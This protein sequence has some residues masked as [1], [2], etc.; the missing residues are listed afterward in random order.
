MPGSRSK[1]WA[2]SLSPL[3]DMAPTA[4]LLPDQAQAALPIGGKWRIHQIERGHLLDE[5]RSWGMPER[6]A[7]AIV[8]GT[9]ERLLADLEPRAAK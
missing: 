3:Y 9:L 6:H 5:A 4:W 1:S 2:V 7:D 8:V